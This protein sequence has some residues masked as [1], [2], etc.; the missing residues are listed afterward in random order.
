MHTSMNTNENNAELDSRNIKE[1]E[2]D[3]G[4]LIS[5]IWAGKWLIISLTLIFSV[6]AIVYAINLPN[7]YKSEVLVAPVEQEQSLGG[8]QGQLG[9]LASL[10]GINLGSGSN[11]KSQLAIEILKSRYFTANFISKH[12]ILLDLMASESW[13]FDS[14]KIIYDSDIYDVINNTW[15]RDVSLPLKPKPSMQEAYE[16]FSEIMHISSDQ[17]TG[18]V[19]VSVEHVSPFIAQQWATWL[20]EDIN[21]TM[22]I[23]DVKEAQESTEFLTSELEKIQISDIRE[24]L[25]SLIEEQTKTIMFANVRDEYVFKTID[26][27][28][29]LEKKSG[30]NRAIICILGMMLGG[31]LGLVIV[32]FRYI[33]KK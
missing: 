32:V 17:D 24:V 27:A 29:V 26:P 33:S 18:M 7:V 11:G 4:E 25:F 14:N 20:V 31:V 5:V 23:R 2:I 1:D 10:A 28:L 22:K 19:R 30:P 21:I 8:L 12:N 3:L 13:A 6:A 9:G 15:V 16:V